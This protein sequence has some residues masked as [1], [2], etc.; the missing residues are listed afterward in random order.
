MPAVEA[1]APISPFIARPAGGVSCPATVP[2]GRSAFYSPMPAASSASPQS[3]KAVERAILRSRTGTGSRI[4]DRARHGWCPPSCGHAQAR[5]PSYL[6]PGSRAPPSGTP[7]RSPRRQRTP[8]RTPRG[9]GRRRAPR[10]PVPRGPLDVGRQVA[11]G[12][13]LVACI[14]RIDQDTHHLD[15]AF[16]HRLSIRHPSLPKG[17][18]GGGGIRTHG[19][20]EDAQRLSRPPH[21][22]ALPPLRAG[23]EASLATRLSGW[24]VA[25]LPGPG[26]RRG[27][28]LRSRGSRTACRTPG[29]CSRGSGR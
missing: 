2:Q 7:P 3:R 14:P 6:A 29:A 22:T 1:G 17:G 28:A 8:A 9:R 20:P 16:R 26:V 15:I 4:P 25:S 19:T 21:S 11:G 24:G 10:R 23:P 12:Q 5:G 27:R 18:S 13:L